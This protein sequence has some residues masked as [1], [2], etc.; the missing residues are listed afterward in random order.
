M[1][2][3]LAVLSTRQSGQVSWIG[4]PGA[5]AL[6]GFAGTAVVALTCA[7]ICRNPTSRVLRGV[8]LPALALGLL[9]LP[10]LLLLLVSLVTPCTWT[11]MC[12]TARA[13]PR[14]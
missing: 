12:S 1:V 13:A 14:C 6:A 2:A 8:R 3:P 9:V 10:A 4:G 11:A 5:G 7:A